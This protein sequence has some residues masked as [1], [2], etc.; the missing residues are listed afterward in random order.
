MVHALN[1]TRRGRSRDTIEM[2]LFETITTRF[3]RKRIHP[4]HKKTYKTLNA[5][6]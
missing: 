1:Y 6:K 2:F 4:V 3:R 5:R